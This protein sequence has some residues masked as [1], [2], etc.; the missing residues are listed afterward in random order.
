[1][2]LNDIKAVM[3]FF[4]VH[5]K[6]D[7]TNKLERVLS[8]ANNEK[9]REE[10]SAMIEDIKTKLQVVNGAAIKPEHFSLKKYEDIE[11]IHAMVMKKDNFSVSEMDAIVSELGSMRDRSD[12]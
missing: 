6:I 11:E 5:V 8:L 3:V 1:M 7:K 10:I 9:N 2:R 12:N 4:Q